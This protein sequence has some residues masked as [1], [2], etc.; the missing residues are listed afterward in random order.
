[1]VYYLCFHDD[2]SDGCLTDI[3]SVQTIHTVDPEH[4]S[5]FTD[6]ILLA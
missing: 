3:S 4:A 6:C 1:M 2:S 5:L